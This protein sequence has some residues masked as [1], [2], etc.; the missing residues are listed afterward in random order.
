MTEPRLSP[1]P[2][3]EWDDET[4]EMMAVLGGLGEEGRVLNVFTTL[5]HHPKLLKRWNVFGAHVLIKTSL[6][7]R[8]RELLILRTGW[9]CR[10]PYEWGQHVIIARELGIT[11][12][13]ISRIAEG[14]DAGWGELEA[15]ALR[16]VDELSEQRTI[17]DPTWEVLSRHLD[18]QQLLDLIF[19]VGQY[20]TVAMF[21]NAVRI[22]P[23][24][25][26]TGV[27]TP[28]RP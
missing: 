9:V 22:E 11:D 26:V 14:P 3:S 1:V 4:R 18:P 7:E 10:T 13:E 15:A 25:G 23:D 28:R 5:A 19:T 17:T 12:E 27:P 2:E 21:T 20:T 16:A 6:P 8:L 24:D